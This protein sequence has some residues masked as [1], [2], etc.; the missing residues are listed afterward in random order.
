LLAVGRNLKTGSHPAL[1]FHHIDSDEGR[2]IMLKAEG[3]RQGVMTFNEPIQ[4]LFGISQ[5]S[6]F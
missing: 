1:G 3:K 4:D 2:F 5:A 6:G